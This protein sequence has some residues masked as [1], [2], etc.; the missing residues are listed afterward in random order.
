MSYITEKGKGRCG[1]W[2]KGAPVAGN[3]KPGQRKGCFE[4]GGGGKQAAYFGGGKRG[5]SPGKGALQLRRKK[6]KAGSKA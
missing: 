5:V 4:L 6:R 1:A 2:K 3:H